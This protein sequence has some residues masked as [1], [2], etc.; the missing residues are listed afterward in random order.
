MTRPSEVPSRIIAEAYESRR[1]VRWRWRFRFI[2]FNN[3]KIGDDY[4]TLDAARRGLK[5]IV[6]PK[7]EVHLRIR[8]RDGT[9]E[10]VGRIR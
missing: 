4:N 6:R 5:L 3:E 1:L 9:V 8:Y 2:G 7:T 10:H